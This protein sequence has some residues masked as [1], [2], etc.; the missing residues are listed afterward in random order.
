MFD[1]WVPLLLIPVL[2][3]APIYTTIRLKLK[4]LLLSYEQIPSRLDSPPIMGGSLVVRGSEAVA[5]ASGTA[6]TVDYF[7]WL[8][9]DVLMIFSMGPT[10]H[11]NYKQEISS[12]YQFIDVLYNLLSEV[13]LLW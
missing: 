4:Y 2:F 6:E 7:G 9:L 13:A 3:E 8:N 5:Q 10:I 12:V 11:S 1:F